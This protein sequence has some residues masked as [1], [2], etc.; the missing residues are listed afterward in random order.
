MI[1]GRDVLTELGLNIKLSEHVI[2]ADDEPFNG[3][4][5]PMVDLVMYIFKYLNIGKIIPEESFTNAY[6]A[7]VYE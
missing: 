1:L 4:T 2:K 6:V 5:P 3:Y 7:E